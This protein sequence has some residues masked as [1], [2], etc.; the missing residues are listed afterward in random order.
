MS[1]STAPCTR[2]IAASDPGSSPQTVAPGHIP[3]QC[4]GLPKVPRFVGRSPHPTSELSVT[5]AIGVAGQCGIRWPPTVVPRGPRG[6]YRGSVP[7][8]LNGHA[9]A[10]GAGPH[11]APVED[12]LR[13]LVSVATVAD[14][15][16]A[17]V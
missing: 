13:K 6:T 10:V 1:F 15:T 3:W 9:V 2:A 5:R 4:A 17:A 12:F 14:A 16:Q 7:S 8:L 11:S